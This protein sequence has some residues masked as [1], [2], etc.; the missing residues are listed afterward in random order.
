MYRFLY[1]LKRLSEGREDG[2]RRFAPESG[3]VEV[4]DARRCPLYDRSVVGMLDRMPESMLPT[5]S[6]RDLYEKSGTLVRGALLLPLDDC[7]GLATSLT[8]M[9]A[10][11]SD[12]KLTS[13]LSRSPDVRVG[14]GESCARFKKRSSVERP[15]PSV[16]TDEMA[17][18]GE[19]L[20]V[21]FDARSSRY[22]CASLYVDSRSI[23]A[24]S[25]CSKLPEIAGGEKGE[26]SRGFEECPKASLVGKRKPLY[27]FSRCCANVAAAGLLALRAR[28]EGEV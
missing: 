23:I 5:E 8:G 18:F 21:Y 3:G 28:S 26:V 25:D 27:D 16:S 7:K 11:E 24:S 1:M 17:M 2:L 4:V 14:A 12:C 6:R 20:L 15:L 9:K 10:A 13:R 22:S 19:S